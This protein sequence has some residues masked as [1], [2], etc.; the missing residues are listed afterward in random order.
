MESP[1][2]GAGVLRARLPLRLRAFEHIQPTMSLSVSPVGEGSPSP[3]Q[4]WNPA[5]QT[6]LCQNEEGQSRV[7]EAVSL[8]PP[9]GGSAWGPCHWEGL[10][11]AQPA[12]KLVRGPGP[13]STWVS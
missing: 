11:A 9:Q 5:Q 13:L 6:Q 12:V 10:W 7:L 8:K 3:S 1:R 2:L 4:P